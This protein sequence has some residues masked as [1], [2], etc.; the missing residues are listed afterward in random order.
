MQDRAVVQDRAVIRLQTNRNN[1]AE[2]EFIRTQIIPYGTR[3][4]AVSVIRFRLYLTE[5]GFW[6]IWFGPKEKEYIKKLFL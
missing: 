1:S 6:K 2:Y 5:Y 3:R 4:I